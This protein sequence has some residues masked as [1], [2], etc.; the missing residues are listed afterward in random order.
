MVYMMS[1]QQY[2][3]DDGMSWHPHVMFFVSGDSE[4]S[5]GANLP[6]S[7]VMAAYDPEQRA[8]TFFVLADKWSDGTP[9][10]PI[11]H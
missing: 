9:G 2:L 7:P 6:G 4:K 11:T 5:W 1:K 10:P 3:N 8:T